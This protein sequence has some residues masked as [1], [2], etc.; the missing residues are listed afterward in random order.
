M[1]RSLYADATQGQSQHRD[2]QASGLVHRPLSA[3]NMYG[4]RSV[5]YLECAD[6]SYIED[7]VHGHSQE[8]TALPIGPWSQLWLLAGHTGRTVIEGTGGPEARGQGAGHRDLGASSGATLVDSLVTSALENS[9]LLEH[10]KEQ[11]YEP[12]MEKAIRPA[13]ALLDRVRAVVDSPPR[14]R[15]FRP[16]LIDDEAE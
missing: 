9:G 15:E 16:P 1:P 8:P 11:P 7:L 4:P 13:T 5:E 12:T 2:S 3:L 6:L 14:H 10:M